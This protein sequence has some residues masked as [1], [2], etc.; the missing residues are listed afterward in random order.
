MLMIDWRMFWTI[1]AVIGV[2]LAGW[3]MIGLIITLMDQFGG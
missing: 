1:L 2:V 3:L